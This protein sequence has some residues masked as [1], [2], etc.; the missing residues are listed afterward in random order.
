VA[1]SETGSRPDAAEVA[2]ALPLDSSD[3]PGSPPVTNTAP[4]ISTILMLRP[5]RNPAF[6]DVFIKVP[7]PHFQS[8]NS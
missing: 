7:L 1:E 4:T 2:V 8:L 6:T 3:R 5:A